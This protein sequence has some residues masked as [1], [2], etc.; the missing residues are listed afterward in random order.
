MLDQESTGNQARNAGLAR[1]LTLLTLF[2]IIATASVL[3][4]T[5]LAPVVASDL[6]IGAHWIGYQISLIYAF[7]LIASALAGGFVGRVGAARMMRLSVLLFALGV[8]LVAMGRVETIVLASLLLGLGYGFNNPVS[9]ELLHKVAPPRR[10]ALIFSIKQSG[11]PMGAVV[12]NLGLPA[13]AFAFGL[14]WELAVLWLAIAAVALSWP[15]MRTF[16]P[17]A[18]WT[19][20]AI[21]GNVFSDIIAD[22]RYMLRSPAQRALAALGG[23]YSAAQ[24][25][26]TAF[27]V[28]TLVAQGWDTLSAGA[29]AAA[30]QATGVVARIAWGWVADRLG[31]F[32]VLAFIGATIA[33]LSVLIVGLSSVPTWL[34]AT[35][36]VAIGFVVSG[37]N[38][39]M[40]AATAQTAPAG[41]V[42]RNTG[43]VLVYTFLGAMVG[44]SMFAAIYSVTGSYPGS[45]LIV[46]LCGLVGMIVAL[47]ARRSLLPAPK[48]A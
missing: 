4:L 5:A 1:V 37:W 25:T 26:V 34:Q 7:G 10:R 21:T 36:F 35:I 45:F 16:R 46:M 44:P 27:V 43:A 39:V 40:L 6:G 3:A 32:Q 20:A 11:V 13:L 14:S 48:T 42:G 38:G 12:A 29:V 47:G 9:S 23:L 18:G 17:Q 28:V 33:V 2:Q 22:Q 31:S 8:V 19:R 41:H 24:L 30:M 15:L